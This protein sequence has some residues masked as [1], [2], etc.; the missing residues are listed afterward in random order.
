[1]DDTLGQ[2]AEDDTTTTEAGAEADYGRPVAGNED[3]T[4]NSPLPEQPSRYTH[5]DDD[6]EEPDSTI[7]SSP[8][9]AAAHSTPRI[10]P[11]TARSKAKARAKSQTEEASFAEYPSLYETL[12]RELQGGGGKNPEKNATKP[13]PMTPGKQGLPDLSMTPTSSPFAAPPSTAQRF[14]TAGKR[15]NDPLLHR[16][17]DKTYRIAATPHTARRQQAA[18]AAAK[19]GAGKSTA[20]QATPL[21]ST[22]RFQLPDSSPFSPDVPAPELRADIFSSPMRQPQRQGQPRTPGV[23]VQ[24]PGKKIQPRGRPA[25]DRADEDTRAGAVDGQETESRAS[26]TQQE[27]W[28]EDSDED[29]VEA[30]L[31]FSPPKTMQFHV[32]QSRLLRTPAREASKRIV[33]DLLLTAGADIT[34][35]FDEDDVDEGLPVDDSPSV[36]RQNREMDETF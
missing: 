12:K 13:A 32:P 31:G 1:L 23:S 16:V 5:Q 34:D 19:A 26:S 3:D 21:A 28:D 30:D 27:V 2:D 24:T 4:V 29:D 10:P 33:E 36:V 18:A 22:S 25:M 8:S 7:L 20:A 15:N 11:T 17:L 35:D 9:V 14:G 6:D